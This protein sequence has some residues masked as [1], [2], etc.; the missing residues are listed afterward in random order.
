MSKDTTLVIVCY[1]S[2]HLIGERLRAYAGRPVVVVDNASTDGS[3][4]LISSSYPEVVLIKNDVNRG[5]G[6]A[7]N[8]GFDRV[9]TKF[10][11]LVNPDVKMGEIEIAALES[12]A[13]SLS[14]DSGWLF[15]APNT[16]HP[17]DS[18]QP[19]T[20]SL[21]RIQSAS[22]AALLF[23]M[24]ALQM[25]GAFDEK[26]FLFF[27]ETDLC[28]RALQKGWVMFYARDIRAEHE[29]GTSTKRTSKI[30]FTRKWH[31]GWSSLSFYRKHR[32]WGNFVRTIF[33]NLFVAG[34]KL[35][36]FRRD[37]FRLSRLYARH[38]SARAFLA[39]RTAFDPSGGPCLESS[40]EEFRRLS[41]R[42]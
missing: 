22:G 17:P 33:R 9:E 14:S 10:A 23:N 38:H 4:E 15:I 25:L 19:I 35:R 26:F 27:E 36:F 1:N 13:L 32:L 37:E 30:A 2:G 8:T 3:R 12:E 20:A 28:R 42:G 40:E 39:G 34:I 16:G 5:F 41:D 24:H 21:D 7:A 11:L 18:R 6:C 31:F 29:L